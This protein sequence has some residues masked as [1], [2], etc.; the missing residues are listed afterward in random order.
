MVSK[1]LKDFD[2]VQKFIKGESF[3]AEYKF[4]G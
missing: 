1:S 4:D 2:D 3:S